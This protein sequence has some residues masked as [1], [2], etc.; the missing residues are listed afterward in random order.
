MADEPRAQLEN[1]D[2]VKKT[3][4]RKILSSS[5]TGS[6]RWFSGKFQDSMA[7]VREHSKPDLFITMTCNP[8]WK[9]IKDEL[10]EG[11]SVQDRPEVVARIFK[12]KCD[13]LIK[14]LVKG[15][16]FGKVAAYMWVIEF[17]K[18]GLPHCHILLILASKDRLLTPYIV[19][20]MVCAELPQ[21]PDDIVDPAKKEQCQRLQNI[22]LTNMCHG[23]CGKDNPKSPCM[24]DGKCSKGFPKDFVKETIVD[25]SSYYATYRRRGPE[26]GGRTVINKDGKKVDNSFVVPY[27]VFL[28]LKFNC[29]INVELCCSP[30]ASK[31]LFK[32]VTKGQDRAMVTTEIDGQPRDEI[33]DYK[34][35]RS[36]GSSEAV[37]HL[38]NFPISDR[39]P[40]V[41][42]LRVHMKDQQQVVFDMEQEVE[43][44]D[45]C[46]ETE[47]TAFF[48]FNSQCLADGADAAN[49]P[50]YVDMPKEHC[51]NL[52]TKKWTKKKQ[53]TEEFTQ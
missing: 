5:F 4:G 13:Q 36:V 38:L 29:H 2:D 30:K 3:I 16:I 20:Q 52:S 48:N 22:V 17:Q 46:R 19:N 10:K 31:Y 37:W 11:Q 7:I 44:M 28:L 32:Y 53:S 40:A 45:K 25:P 43:A 14:D 18:R 34:D 42:A 27:N 21:N 39:H 12:R 15:E 33:E 1:K 6:P 41:K 8:N 26:D 49:L 9:E 23:P 51:Y 47:L 35:M 24:V 50:K